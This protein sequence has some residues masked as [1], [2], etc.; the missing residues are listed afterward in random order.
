MSDE[1]CTLSVLPW[2]LTDANCASLRA[3][4]LKNCARLAPATQDTWRPLLPDKDLR[5]LL[6]RATAVLEREPTVVDVALGLPTEPAPRVCVVGDVHGQVFDLCA[7]LERIAAMEPPV[8]TVVFTGDY[9]DR[10]SWGVECLVALLTLKLRGA[11]AP[12]VRVRRSRS[13]SASRSPAASPAPPERPRHPPSPPPVVVSPVAV[14]ALQE[15]K[16]QPPSSEIS[17]SD[18]RHSDEHKKEHHEHKHHHHHHHNH[19]SHDSKESHHSSGSSSRSSKSSKSSKSKSSEKGSSSREGSPGL[20]AKPSS[21]TP[22]LTVVVDEPTPAEAAT[23]ETAEKEPASATASATTT[24]TGDEKNRVFV[25]SPLLVRRKPASMSF[26][27]LPVAVVPPQTTSPE[28]DTAPVVQQPQPQQP[29]QQQPQTPK[30]AKKAVRPFPHVVLLRGNH[31]SS[32]CVNTYGF[33][34]EVKAKYSLSM[35]PL[36]RRLFAALPLA[37]VARCGRSLAGPAC[38]SPLPLA[39]PI[40]LACSTPTSPGAAPRQKLSKGVLMVHGGLWRSRAAIRLATGG[41]SSAASSTSTTPPPQSQQQHP[42]GSLELGQLKELRGLVR[43]RYEDA[44]GASVVA[45]VLWS[46]PCAAAGV[47]ANARRDMGVEYGPDASA[48]F[49]RAH[50][51]RL[52]VRSHEGPDA[53]DKRRGEMPDVDAGYAVDHRW[54]GTDEPAVV[55][56]FSAPA[57]PQ[58]RSAAKRDPARTTRGAYAVLLPV[59]VSRPR[60]PSTAGDT[61]GSEDAVDET[62]SSTPTSSCSSTSSTSSTNNSSLNVRWELSFVQFDAEPHPPGIRY[63]HL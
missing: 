40:T 46:D 2:P 39:E 60:S 58:F 49:L 23:S 41:A 30:K 16:P 53:R 48:A 33:A 55:T 10:G 61:S 5:F 35:L 31:E 56:V 62:S 57:Y 42:E 12:G 6:E 34:A 1:L 37:A 17:T 47:R 44:V 36:F 19:H 15:A 13:L 43:T 21:G 25:R 14:D 8:H 50:R 11:R 24:Q 26:S 54:P 9:V 28:A 63:P 29:Q 38:L 32:S 59:E 18:E 4:L 51:L 7:T 52:L 20:D 27:S 3:K 45:D 22:H